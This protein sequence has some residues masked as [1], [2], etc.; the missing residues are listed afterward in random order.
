MNMKSDLLVSKFVC[1]FNLYRYFEVVVK[2]LRDERRQQLQNRAA[3]LVIN[4]MSGRNREDGAQGG[5]DE[6]PV[7]LCTR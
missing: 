5:G 4:G 7:G 3:M 1:K 6:D 2:A